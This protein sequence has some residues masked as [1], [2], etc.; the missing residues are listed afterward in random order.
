MNSATRAEKKAKRFVI[1]VSVLLP[2]AVGALYLLPKPDDVPAPMRNCFNQLPLFNAMV[3]G[4]TAIILIVAY[5]AIRR[6]KIKLHRWLMTTALVL[7]VVFLLS[8]ITYH[9]T[10]QHT[11]YGGQGW[12]KTAY[13]LL[14]LSHIL[15]S[16]AIVPLVLIS[17]T[18]ALAERFDRHR[19][20]AR[21]ALPLWLY[22]AVTGVVVYLMIKSYYP[23]NI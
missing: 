2:L 16:I 13:L 22:V 18:R 23:H 9:F 5:L 8:Y 11:S 10:T 14:L 15:C 17:Y 21:I 1:V 19:K 4:T 7:S 6:K 12:L 20:I 3:N